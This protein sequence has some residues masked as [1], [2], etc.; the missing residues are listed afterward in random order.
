MPLWSKVAGGRIRFLDWKTLEVVE[1]VD[2]EFKITGQLEAKIYDPP[3]A[4]LSGHRPQD[5][6]EA[7]AAET[8]A[9]LFE[10]KLS[11]I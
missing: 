7:G 2:D 8:G 3:C 9:P 1:M 4:V 11:S 6:V 10:M 5:N